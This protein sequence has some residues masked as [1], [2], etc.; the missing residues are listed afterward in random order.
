MDP[1]LSSFGLLLAAAGG[2][3][4]VREHFG[5]G[6]PGYD[7]NNSGVHFS[8][9]GVDNVLDLHGDIVNPDLVVFFSGNQFMM[10]PE[11][12]RAFQAVFPR[13]QRIYFETLP[14]GV[15]EQQIRTGSLTMGNLLVRIEPDVLTCSEQRIRRLNETEDWF[16]ELTP[17][18]RNRLVLMVRQ[19][20]PK[21]VTSWNDLGHEDIRVS[22]PD[23][24]TEG[25]GEESLKILRK[26]GGEPL[27]HRV[28]EQKA[29]NGTTFITQIHHRQTPLRIMHDL[30]DV[31]PVWLPEAMLQAQIGN[32]IDMVELSEDQN[33]MSIAVAGKFR[34]APHSQAARD[35]LFFLRSGEAQRIYGKFGFLPLGSSSRRSLDDGAER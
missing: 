23:P 24:Q 25:I 20:N 6:P 18:L 14:P 29:G 13:H 19:G 7:A 16:D 8:V 12:I 35:F 15:L 34:D 11:L 27:V 28:M 5:F 10:V 4:L 21:H 32:P 17:Y 2:L 9:C 30:S 26:V 33:G 22:M 3:L 31:G 1:L